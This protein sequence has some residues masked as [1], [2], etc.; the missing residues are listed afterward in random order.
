MKASTVLPVLLAA[1]MTGVMGQPVPQ[2]SGDII[3]RERAAEPVAPVQPVNP[4]QQVER[5]T[6]EER[7]FER[8]VAAHTA[9]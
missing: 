3:I 5:A 8:P 7:V 2:E 1:P 9:A 4:V 6:E